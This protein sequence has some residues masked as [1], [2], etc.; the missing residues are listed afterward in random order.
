MAVQ[1]VC[2]EGTYSPEQVEKLFI[3]W[4]D[5]NA[6]QHRYSLMF[7]DDGRAA[8]Q[9]DQLKFN[10]FEVGLMDFPIEEVLRKSMEGQG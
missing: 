8:F 10:W 2:L 7:S 3:K 1:L 4:R 9:F 6:D 5:E